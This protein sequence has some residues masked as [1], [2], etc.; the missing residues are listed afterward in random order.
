MNLPL[1]LPT[2]HYAKRM[3]W[4]MGVA[5]LLITVKCIVVWWAMNHWAVPFHPLW[6]VAPTVVF[7]AIASLLWLTHEPE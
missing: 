2:E 5:W 3:R 7:A 6:I 4:F 1:H